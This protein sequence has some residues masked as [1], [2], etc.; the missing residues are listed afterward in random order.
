MSKSATID[1]LDRLSAT[2]D[3]VHYLS[4]ALNVLITAAILLELPSKETFDDS[5]RSKGQCFSETGLDTSL[6]CA[7][8]LTTSSIALLSLHESR[9]KRWKNRLLAERSRAMA[10]SNLTHGLGHGFIYLV[11]GA[12]PPTEL[13]WRADAVAYLLVLVA[14]WPTVLMATMRQVTPRQAICVGLVVVAVQV[15]VDVPTHLQFSYTQAIILLLTSVDQLALSIEEKRA[16][17]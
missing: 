11:G 7:A 5:W 9:G 17:G 10:I 15:A 14:F 8:L 12:I 4:I 1:G 16:A 13:V 2:G 3:S 6:T